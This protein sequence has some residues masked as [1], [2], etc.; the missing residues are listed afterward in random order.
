MREYLVT[1][2]ISA[3][4]CYLITPFVRSQALRFG[5]VAEIRGRDIHTTP[6]ARWG[7]VAMWLAMS[8]TFMIVNHLPLV[9]KSFGHEAQGIFLASTTI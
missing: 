2:L 3:A 1:L 7:G 6:T 5:A 8:V 9:G 4:L